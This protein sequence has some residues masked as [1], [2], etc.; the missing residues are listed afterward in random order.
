[1][2]YITGDIH[3]EYKR[4]ENKKLKKLNENDCLIVCGD[5][6][7]IWNNSDKEKQILKKICDKKYKTLFVDGTHENFALLEQYPVVELYGGRAGKIGGN[8]YHLL[9][10]E[11]YT[12]E[13]QTY[14]TFGGGES[15]DK[16]LRK[17][18]GTWWVQEQPTMTEMQY[19]VEQL[20]K[21]QRT[22]DY[23]ITHQP[24]MTDMALLERKRTV[25]PL[26]TFFDELSRNI[27]YQKWYFGC[28]HKNKKVRHSQCLFTDIVKIT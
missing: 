3:G 23:V 19:A 25:N 8:L 13:N 1:M 2:V 20:D 24:P 9:R 21:I 15:T 10:G 12:I 27:T 5:F 7:F 4:F 17:E 28:L 14:F 6:G 16:E 18:N 26:A 22:V 11:I